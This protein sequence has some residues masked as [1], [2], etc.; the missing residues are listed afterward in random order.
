MDA[1]IGALLMWLLLRLLS[2]IGGFVAVD[3]YVIQE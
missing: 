3:L 2:L 1:P